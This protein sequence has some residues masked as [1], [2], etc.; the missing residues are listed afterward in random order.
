VPVDGWEKFFGDL[1]PWLKAWAEKWT[2]LTGR[3]HSF[4]G[5][6]SAVGGWNLT[7]PGP[8]AAQ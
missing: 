1:Y 8:P 6:S 7:R 5:G 2:E 4:V 3:V